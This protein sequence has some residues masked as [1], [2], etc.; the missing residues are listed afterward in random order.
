MNLS[1]SSSESRCVAPRPEAAKTPLARA[2]DQ[3]P[4]P[5]SG[6]RCSAQKDRA[7]LADGTAPSRRA[8]HARHESRENG[9]PRVPRLAVSIFPTNRAPTA[10]AIV[11]AACRAPRPCDGRFGRAQLPRRRCRPFAAQL[12]GRPAT[13]SFGTRGLAPQ[14]A[15][16]LMLGNRH[17]RALRRDFIHAVQVH[18]A[19][20]DSAASRPPRGA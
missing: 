13:F 3:A 8:A 17:Y 12:P 4:E 19:R 11:N 18:I 2:P 9:S 16:R 6:L 5:R 7:S 14:R 1:R 15:A 10:I 20:L